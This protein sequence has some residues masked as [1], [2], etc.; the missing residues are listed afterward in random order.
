MKSAPE[1]GGFF[2]RTAESCDCFINSW[3]W[4]RACTTCFLADHS[5]W[6]LFFFSLSALGWKDV[7]ICPQSIWVIFPEVLF[8]SRVTEYIHGHVQM[9]SKNLSFLLREDS[10]FIANAY[11]ILLL[12]LSNYKTHFF[13]SRFHFFSTLFRRDSAEEHWAH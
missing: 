1:L 3:C 12:L 7:K 4:W 11:F 2:A 8:L 13:N 10:C 5:F 9:Y 6:K